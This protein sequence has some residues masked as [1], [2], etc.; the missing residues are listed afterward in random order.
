MSASQGFFLSRRAL[1]SPRG[2]TPCLSRVKSPLRVTSSFACRLTFFHGFFRIGRGVVCVRPVRICDQNP[3][4]YPHKQRRL[5]YEDSL[6]TVASTSISC[7]DTRA[8][9][10]RFPV[11]LRNGLFQERLSY[12]T[13]SWSGCETRLVSLVEEGPSLGED[14]PSST[15]VGLCHE[16]F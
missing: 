6:M 3:F 13:T 8:C 16:S 7:K 15:R 1:P 2:L 12:V 11:P 10:A 5:P 14:F 9:G 4:R